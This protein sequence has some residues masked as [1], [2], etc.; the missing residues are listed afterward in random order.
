MEQTNTNDL[1]GAPLAPIARLFGLNDDEVRDLAKIF[2][3]HYNHPY[4]EE[5][6]VPDRYKRFLDATLYGLIKRNKQVRPQYNIREGLSLVQTGENDAV[7]SAIDDPSDENDALEPLS[8]DFE[9]DAACSQLPKKEFPVASVSV[10]EIYVYI[11]EQMRFHYPNLQEFVKDLNDHPY[12]FLEGNVYEK[13]FRNLISD[14]R[15]GTGENDAD[16]Q[17]GTG[18]NAKLK[19]SVLTNDA[20]ADMEHL[21]APLFKMIQGKFL[22]NMIQGKFPRKP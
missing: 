20:K 8:D 21:V 1:E 16:E 4:G 17:E 2:W 5:I 14:D 6:P 13:L 10:R 19:L 7:N 3:K 12:Y 22:F 11:A 18:E 9:K 15:E